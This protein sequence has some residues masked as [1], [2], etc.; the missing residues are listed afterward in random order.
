M[1]ATV[2][3]TGVVHRR[4]STPSR[5]FSSRIP[6]GTQFAATRRVTRFPTRDRRAVVTA[7]H[8]PV[9]NLQFTPDSAL[10]G[11]LVLGSMVVAKRLNAGKN[12]GISGETKAFARGQGKATNASFLLG[13]IAA[14]YLAP[15]ILGAQAQVAMVEAPRAII[16]GALV[17]FG[18]SLGCGCT[19]GH[20]ISGNGQLLVRSMVYTCVFMAVGAAVVAA[21]GTLD[22]LHVSQATKTLDAVAHSPEAKRLLYG[23]VLAAGVAI[24]AILYTFAKREGGGVTDVVKRLEMVSEHF[25]GLFFGLGLVISGMTNPAKVAGFLAVTSKAFD[26]SLM[27][28]MGGALA[29]VVSARFF[30]RNVLGVTRP[31]MARAFTTAPKYVDNKLLL[32]AVLFG[33]GW[34]LAGICPGPGLVS[35]SSGGR[36]ITL[37]CAAYLLGQ[38]VHAQLDAEGALE[39]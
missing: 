24:Q 7:H 30:A 20:G 33:A 4:A 21:T 18:S 23:K 28:V 17:G 3:S 1:H 26:P 27:F 16:A 15:T 25:A 8:G 34:G 22:E 9:M 37:W 14:G 12:L 13:L 32:G 38:K 10:A 36:E 5:R 31:S 11:G 29:L 39:M 6:E 2:A 35:L 19:S